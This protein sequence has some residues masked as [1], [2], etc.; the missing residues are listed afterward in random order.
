[1]DFEVFKAEVANFTL[2][3]IIEIWIEANTGNYESIDTILINI[4]K[5]K[6]SLAAP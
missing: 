4:T 1:M 2:C 3:E 5:K 6:G